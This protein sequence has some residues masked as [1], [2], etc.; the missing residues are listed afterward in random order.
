M[1]FE[2]RYLAFFLLFS[3][4]GD[5][6]WFSRGNLHKS[7]QLMLEL[8]R[9]PFLVLHFS[10]YTLINLSDDVICD[11]AIYTDDTTLYSNCDQASD[12]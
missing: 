9:A 6:G 11:I 3:V 8:L 7:I 4:M 12:L 2:V 5:F 1:G 10:Y